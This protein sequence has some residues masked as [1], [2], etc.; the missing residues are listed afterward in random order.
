MFRFSSSRNQVVNVS[1]FAI[2]PVP[3]VFLL[4]TWP[5]MRE[6]KLGLVNGK[7]LGGKS[8]FST[9]NRSTDLL[10]WYMFQLAMLG[11]WHW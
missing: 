2:A 9:G 5:N 7:L 11:S 1:L 8:S 6:A 10:S 3:R 4:D